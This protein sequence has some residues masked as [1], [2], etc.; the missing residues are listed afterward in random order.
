V[1]LPDHSFGGKLPESQEEVEEAKF[2]ESDLNQALLNAK[3]ARIQ[4]K[5]KQ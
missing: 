4:Q 2:K 5:D 1:R 3:K